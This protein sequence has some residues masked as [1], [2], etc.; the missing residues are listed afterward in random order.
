MAVGQRLWYGPIMITSPEKANYPL[1]D[2]PHPPV[3]SRCWQ[4][5][6]P[7][8]CLSASPLSVF[9]PFL[10]LPP[11]LW[12]IAS[13][14]PIPTGLRPPAQRLRRLG[15]YLGAPPPSVRNPKAGCACVPAPAANHSPQPEA[16]RHPAI[17]HRLGLRVGQVSDLPYPAISRWPG[18]QR[19]VC[20]GTAPAN[21][22]I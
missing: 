19:R 5:V 11:R 18:S 6:C 13:A 16:A 9:V 21:T 4:Y 1:R 17:S 8:W 2:P 12:R 3:G 22:R 7:P 20:A 10:S 15:R 14:S